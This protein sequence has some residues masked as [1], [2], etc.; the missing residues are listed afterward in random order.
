[1]N[2]ASPNKATSP[3]V[4]KK[5]QVTLS[6]EYTGLFVA[7]HSKYYLGVK[8][9]ADI[10]ASLFVL[11]FILSWLTPLLAIIIK[12]GSKGPVFFHQK[13]VGKDGKSFS[14][15]KFRTMIQNTEADDIPASEKD[16]RI[17]TAGR[18]LRKANMDELPQFFNVLIGDMSIVGPRPHMLTDC[19]RFSFVVHS[20]SFRHCMR[21]GITGWAQVNG[22]HGPVDSHDSIML[23]YYWDAMYV[24]KAGFK[25]DMRILYCTLILSVRNFFFALG[26]RKE[27]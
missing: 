20:Y 3:V 9:V 12:V 18:F 14:C 5:A 1:M 25:L 4:L 8:R 21:P 16:E 23:R 22:C 7:P 13:R 11:L 10:F 19:I 26:K 17:T 24:R 27:E 15:F 2:T 6:N